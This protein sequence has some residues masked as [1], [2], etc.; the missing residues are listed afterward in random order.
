MRNLKFSGRRCRLAHQPAIV[1]PAVGPGR[2]RPFMRS[3]LAGGG[4]CC[5]GP[6][7]LLGQFVALQGTGDVNETVPAARAKPGSCAQLHGRGYTS[8]FGKL[9]P[10]T[11]RNG[12]P[13]KDRRSNSSPSIIGCNCPRVT[14]LMCSRTGT[15]GCASSKRSLLREPHAGEDSR[16]RNKSVDS[17]ERMTCRDGP[18]GGGFFAKSGP[19]LPRQEEGPIIVSAADGKGV[20]SC[21]VSR[22][23]RLRICTAPRE[24][25]PVARRWP[26]ARVYTVD[27][28]VRRPE[29]IVA[30]LFGDDRQEPKGRVPSRG[31]PASRR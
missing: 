5:T 27:R 8:I 4:N 18:A 15:K 22:P 28:F 9:T 26:S 24:T 30:A 16:P 21:G 2:Q 29:Q 1:C 14:F 3:N 23:T 25:R 19:G 20:V 11:H 12:S 10:A 7:N 17:L 31:N 6:S 13:A